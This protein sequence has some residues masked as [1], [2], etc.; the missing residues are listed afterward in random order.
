MNNADAALEACQ[1][2]AEEL[3]AA[4]LAPGRA[5]VH[6]ASDLTV[7]P[8]D[9]TV[10]IVGQTFPG[11]LEDGQSTILCAL[12]EDGGLL[13][14]A[15]GEGG[16]L[17]RFSPDGASLAWA[18]PGAGITHLRLQ[19]AGLSDWAE[20]GIEG[21]IEQIAWSPDGASLL[22]VVAENGAD[23]AGIHGGLSMA[24]VT[25][26]STRWQPHVLTDHGLGAWRSAWVV[27]AATLKPG[28][29]SPPGTNVWQACWAGGSIV[30]VASDHHGEAAWYT[31]S[32]RR[33][34]LL[35]GEEAILHEPVDQIGCPTTTPDGRSLFFI[36]AFCS[37]R[38][39]VCGTLKQ[40]DLETGSVVVV[41]TGDVEVSHVEWG[42]DRAVF[43]GM[44]GLATAVGTLG[45][46]GDATT[47]WRSDSLSCGEWLPW[48]RPHRDGAV[49]VT[50]AFAQPPQLRLVRQGEGA[51]LY[52]FASEGAAATARTGGTARRFAWRAPDGMEIDGLLIEPSGC[53]VATPLVVDIHG[54]PVWANRN[55]WM[56]RGRAT[57][58]MIRRGWR[59]L[60]PNPRGSSGYGQ[61]FA[62][63]VLGD[64]GGADAADILAG[65][66][67]LVAQGL[68]DPNR[69]ACTGSSYGGFMS[70]R[71]L[72]LDQRFAAAA[73]ISPVTN[74]LSQHGTSQIPFFDE[75]F[76]DERLHESA[77]RHIAHSPVMEAHRVA[78]PTLLMAGGRDRNTPA[79]QALEFYTVLA[80]RGTDVALLTYPLEGHSI[81]G[82]PAYLDSAARI[83]AWFDRCFKQV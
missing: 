50:E 14:I 80:G 12:A 19:R 21:V 70:C 34:D 29:A 83:M 77:A 16:C 28:R 13:P 61:A 76:L 51:I 43:A 42:C 64:M 39:L 6:T 81:R 52:N 46:A 30:A 44:A 23:T 27:D 15:G 71:L 1:R 45:S 65:I 32:L 26:A 20:I 38:D 40:L 7:S 5:H 78:T 10:V 82:W 49:A 35:S 54:G 66:D 37:D 25:C 60:Y 48:A 79:G 72:T 22:L 33:I 69:L 3:Y 31:A 17:P 58:M 74:W 18:V 68:A 9:G 55:R 73:P 2:G 53:P 36:E 56:A 59:V 41:E 47:V 63:A 4:L 67:A 75:L 24:D 8:T 57:P 11:V 62:R